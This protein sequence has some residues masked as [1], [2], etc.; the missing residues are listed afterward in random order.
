[1]SNPVIP[2]G[3]SIARAALLALAAV[4]AA[5]AGRGTPTPDRV[6][7]A[8]SWPAAERRGLQSE[9]QSWVQASHSRLRTRRI[10]L[11]WLILEP[12]ADRV[13]LVQRSRPPDLLLG[14]SA[15]SFRALEQADELA[16]IDPTGSV[17][18]RVTS[19]GTVGADASLRPITVNSGSAA[20]QSSQNML[21]A[22]PRDDPIFLAQALLQ[23]K[24]GRWRDGYA[25]L[26]KAAGSQP[27]IQ[28][29]RIEAAGG[30]LGTAVAPGPGEYVAIPRAACEQEAARG[31]ARFLAETRRI[32]PDRGAGAPGSA[33]GADALSLLA[34]LL[35]ATLVDAQDELW[36]AQAALVRAHNPEQARQWLT[37]P[38]PWPPASVARFLERDAERGMSL[39]QALAAEVAPEPA[40]RAWLVRSWLS[41]ARTVD[42]QLIGEL[43][44]VANGLLAH[45]PRFRAWLREEW[46]AWSRQ[47]Y[48][49]VARVLAVHLDPAPK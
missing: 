26:V 14:G 41:P 29:G 45:E 5:C 21:I 35:G 43:A 38:P 16:A 34:D 23:L 10:Q 22:D 20:T 37:E 31:F 7:I 3:G 4:L 36:D 12:G 42:E 44:H 40:A 1:M 30:G 46:T 18:L 24:G 48:R 11:Q 15:A 13:R 25:R 27:R 17:L 32:G 33:A 2:G 28:R 49:R 6:V 47:R 8:T 19:R 9:F 39:T